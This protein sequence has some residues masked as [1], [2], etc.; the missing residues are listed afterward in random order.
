MTAILDKYLDDKEGAYKLA[1]QPMRN[2]RVLKDSLTPIKAFFGYMHPDK[3]TRADIKRYAEANAKKKLSNGST[4]KRLTIFRAAL[5]YALKE[6]WIVQVP[7][8]DMPPPPPP[9]QE[10]MNEKQVKKFLMAC[11]TPHV[12]LFTL[13]ALHTLSRKGAILDLKWQ[14]VDMDRR[15]IDFNPPGRVLTK[16]RRVV[17]PIDSDVLYSALEEALEL[18]I[19]DYVIEYGGK[20]VGNIQKAFNRIADKRAKLPWVTPHIIRHTGAS[21]LAQHGEDIGKIAQLM[22]DNPAT[23]LKHYAKFN[24]NYLKGPVGKLKEIYG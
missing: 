16:K 12:R 3:I 17:V 7:A 13:L 21:L 5:N 9:R 6:K 4:I 24:P 23:V 19:T 11:D 1:K 2:H 15:R 20:P 18:G 14:Q 22:G 8:F 10:Y